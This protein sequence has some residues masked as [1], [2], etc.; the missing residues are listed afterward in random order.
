MKKWVPINNLYGKRD[1]SYVE[2]DRIS[3]RVVIKD[4]LES[5]KVMR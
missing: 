3:M 2:S 1:M 5:E 4:G